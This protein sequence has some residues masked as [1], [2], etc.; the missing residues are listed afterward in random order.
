M[1]LYTLGYK[2]WSFYDF[3]EKV[4]ELGVVV[5]DVRFSPKW[6]SPFWSKS[7]LDKSLKNRYIHIPELG[8]K[9]YSDLLKP[10]EIVDIEVGS[11]QVIE[12]LSLDFDCLLLCACS[13][14]DK[15]HRRVVSDFIQIKTGCEIID[16]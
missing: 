6:Y 7:N 14:A 16:L 11:R 10:I 9:N 12:Y 4:E 3:I 5:I 8:N 1:I 13:D 15:C 2:D